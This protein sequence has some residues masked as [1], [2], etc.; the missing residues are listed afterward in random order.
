MA[1]KAIFLLLA[2]SPSYHLWLAVCPPTTLPAVTYKPKQSLS[3]ST[4]QLSRVWPSRTRTA[5]KSCL[6]LQEISPL[7]CVTT[8]SHSLNKA[9]PCTAILCFSAQ[10]LLSTPLCCKLLWKVN[11]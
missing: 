1:S 4:S 9:E 7:C 10:N 8:C 6:P 11:I 3:H 2:L 5:P